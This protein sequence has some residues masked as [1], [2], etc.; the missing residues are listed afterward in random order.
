MI[1]RLK[2]LK[3]TQMTWPEDRYRSIDEVGMHSYLDG[4]PKELAND[5][6]LRLAM[7]NVLS[8]THDE[9][10]TATKFIQESEI[11]EIYS[12]KLSKPICLP[13]AYTHGTHNDTL[14][15]FAFDAYDLLQYVYGSNEWGDWLLIPHYR[16]GDDSFEDVTLGLF[17]CNNNQQVIE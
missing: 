3:N 11:E 5:Y 2:H 15:Q 13:S 10:L 4:L 14:R 12:V 9:I 7:E 16:L 17:I 6:Y 8:C 1:N